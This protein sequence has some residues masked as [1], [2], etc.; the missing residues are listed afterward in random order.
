MRIVKAIAESG[1]G[2]V[3]T[4][5]G[6]LDEMPIRSEIEVTTNHGKIP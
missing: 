3:V 4:L 6:K 2:H 1:F 5:Q